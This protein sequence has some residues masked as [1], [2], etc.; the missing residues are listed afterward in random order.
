MPH[1]RTLLQEQNQQNLYEAS[2]G[3]LMEIMH[4]RSNEP[5]PE[6]EPNDLL[7]YTLNCGHR[8]RLIEGWEIKDG[9][10]HTVNPQ[11]NTY[12]ERLFFYTLAKKA[13]DEC[14]QGDQGSS[15]TELKAQLKRFLR[16]EYRL[17]DPKLQEDWD[18]AQTV[19]YWDGQQQRLCQQ[20]DGEEV[21]SRWAVRL[22]TLQTLERVARQIA[23]DIPLQASKKPNNNHLATILTERQIHLPAEQY[24]EQHYH[25]PDL[26]GL[27]A[28]HLQNNA[29]IALICFHKS[30]KVM[31]MVQEVQQLEKHLL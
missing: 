30:Q 10:Q 12:P 21:T 20:L 7:D 4:G 19:Q 28:L 29:R 23:E 15:N 18:L 9:Q 25:L 17:L 26:L 5:A 11:T 3:Q 14:Y 2:L 24:G 6:I 8:H 22:C 16:K 27:A 1:L 13:V 31:A